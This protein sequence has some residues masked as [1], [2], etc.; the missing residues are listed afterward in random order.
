MRALK[1][2]FQYGRLSLPSNIF[3]APLA[4]CSGF[5][6]RKVGAHFRPGLMYCEMVKMQA[7]AR[8]DQE[9][10]HLLDYDHTM[11]PIGA[12][13][14]G[15][16][17][18]LAGTCAQIAQDLGFDALDL[19]CGCPVDKVTK[20]GSG[21]GLLKEPRRIG[22]ILAAMVAR[23]QIPVSVKIR[24]GWDSA[25]INCAE[26][27]QIAEQ[28][29][30]TAITVHGRTREQGYRGAADWS[31]IAE[32]KRAASSILV[33]GN[34]DLFDAASFPAMFEKTQCDGFVVARGSLGQPW[35]CQYP[36]APDQSIHCDRLVIS[37]KYL[38]K[39]VESALHYGGSARALVELRKACTWYLQ[40]HPKARGLKSRLCRCADFAEGLD[41]IEQM[42]KALE[43]RGPR[44]ALSQIAQSLNGPF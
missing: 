37:L 28:A 8:L 25:S 5:A 2:P 32:C 1:S 9:T 34:G 42:R 33:L 7:L 30:A 17:I 29:G 13:I 40:R 31:T 20:D 24:A 3:C 26:I 4:G 27:T 38:A 44:P 35:L 39:H 15:A 23:V 14:C 18:A 12:Q 41:L 16:D 21:S 36:A 19:N 22:E 11:H 43:F 6:F 10:L